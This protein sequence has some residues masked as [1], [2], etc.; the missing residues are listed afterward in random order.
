MINQRRWSQ[1]VARPSTHAQ[2]RTES[3]SREETRT[4]RSGCF[5]LI[6]AVQTRR[7][8]CRSPRGVLAEAR[9][10]ARRG[11]PGRR[12]RARCG[13]NPGRRRRDD[14]FSPSRCRRGDPALAEEPPDPPI[15]CGVRVGRPSSRRVPRAPLLSP[16]TSAGAAQARG[17]GQARTAGS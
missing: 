15:G 7:W 17:Q 10:S 3:R 9:G 6:P 14:Y 12:A 2:T 11:A 4:A 13:P 5:K 1:D 8:S 16:Q